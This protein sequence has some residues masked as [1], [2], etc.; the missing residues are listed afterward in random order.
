VIRLILGLA[1]AF[2]CGAALAADQPH[3]APPPAW[4]KPAAIPPTPAQPVSAA[5]QVLLSDRQMRFGPDGDEFYSE[6]AFRVLTPAGLALVN[7]LAPSWNPETETLT[8]HRF[9]LIRDGKVIDLL[10][11]GKNVTVVR[12]ETN[13]ELAMLD[14]DLTAA[15]QPE[16]VQVGDIVELS[17]TLTRH[18]PIMHGYSQGVDALRH[19]GVAT[20]LRIRALWPVS[21]SVRWLATDGIPAPKIART[22]DGTELTVDLNDIEAPKPPANAPGRFS[23]IGSVQFSQFGDWASV[24]SLMAPLY[25]KAETLA[26]SSPLKLEARKIAAQ[27]PNPKL[28][29]QAALR[30]VQDQVR[31]AFIGMNLGGFTPADA[32]VTWSR[33]FGD[34]KGKTAL[35]LALLHELGVE[36]QPALV[37]TDGGDGMDARLPVLGFDHVLVRAMIG[38]KVYWLDGTRTGDRDLD[39]IQVPDFHWALPV[40]PADARLVKLEPTALDQP[41]FESLL[42]LDASGGLDAKSPAHAEN[43][44]RGDTAIGW[45]LT[46]TAAGHAD[47]ERSLRDYWRNRLPWVD[48]KSV[49]FVFDDQHRTMR[50]VM[51]GL[52]AMDWDKGGGAR[53]FQIADSNLGFE[54]SFKR[55]P[56]IHANAP[57]T[58]GFPRYDK[59]TVIIALPRGGDGFGLLNGG[60]VDQTIASVRYQRS[61]RIEGG[62]ATMVAT[63]RALAPEFPATDADDAATQLRRLTAYDVTV[64]TVSDVPS[65]AAIDPPD[66]GPAP[67][68]AAGLAS[69][70]AGYLQRGD[71][72]QAIADLDQAI[73]LEP[74]SAKYAYNRG[75]AHFENHQDD[76]AMADFNRAIA[77]QPDDAFAL[78]GRGQLYLF[79]GDLKRAQADFAA[80]A[81]AAPNDSKRPYREVAAYDNAGHYAEAVKLLDQ[82]IAK[83]PSGWLYNDRCWIRAKSGQELEKALDDCN[84]ALKLEPQSSAV[85][86]SRAFVE[87]R[88]GRFEAAV[89]DYDTALAKVPNQA[90]SLYGRGIAERRKG[91][92]QKGDADIAAARQLEAGVADTFD[93]VGVTP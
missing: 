41:G 52:A 90:P 89:S 67:T 88:L 34:C 18:D 30:L 22:A 47:A 76:L 69:Q 61:T 38:G 25:A 19:P 31:Y 37:D 58:V 44:L 92:K 93:R 20:R 73:K 4:V 55:E 56:G 12:R 70:A 91:D 33:R 39:D 21:K 86:D 85:L 42:R 5:Y 36:A 57:F 6:N 77:L 84:A 40:Q 29:A 71:Y 17:M 50:L 32:D 16:G 46:L 54:A 28:R 27:Y 11:G 62:V 60:D 24:S 64:H 87:L 9:N 63:E 51:D 8:F 1:A 49:D 66:F 81:S 74:N 7:H 2:C 43:L 3:Y 48:I 80:A 14:G 79:K 15:L 53:D 78:D 75:V 45:N 82:L 23:D 83:A 10:A 65:V 13:L 35:L 68:D 59:W 72:R 26:A